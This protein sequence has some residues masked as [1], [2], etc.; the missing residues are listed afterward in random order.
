M[1]HVLI[2]RHP[3]WLFLP[4]REDNIKKKIRLFLFNKPTQWINRIFW[5]SF[6]SLQLR[7]MKSG[8]QG[9]IYYCI[10]CILFAH[11]YSKLLI[12]ISFV[13]LGYS[14]LKQE[15]SSCHDPCAPEDFILRTYPTTSLIIVPQH[16]ESWATDRL[17]SLK[18]STCT[19]FRR[20]VLHYS[21]TEW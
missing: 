15:W 4:V 11:T 12:S 9:W 18:I 17:R 10:L 8:K 14:G 1:K 20:Y 2:S 19:K 7:I 16:T 3:R 13:S 21:L 5:V 6:L